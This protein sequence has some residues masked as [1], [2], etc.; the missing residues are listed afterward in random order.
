MK[1]ET[2][3]ISTS[4]NPK[5][6]PPDEVP[7]PQDPKPTPGPQEYPGPSDPEPDPFPSESP[8]PDV[9]LEDPGNTEIED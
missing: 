6:K 3:A 1:G 9:P 5:Q 8:R 7:M 4:P 2:M